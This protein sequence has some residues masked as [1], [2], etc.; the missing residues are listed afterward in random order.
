M[1]KEYVKKSLLRIKEYGDKTDALGKIGV[2]LIDYNEGLINMVEE[3][4]AI[5]V[6]EDKFDL[7]LEDI[8]WWL[9][10]S[11]NKIITYGDKKVDVNNIDNYVDWLFEHY[12]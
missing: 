6:S 2:N 4:I 10:E 3:S 7:V 1:K 9:Y 11:V 5:V 8:Q 12:A